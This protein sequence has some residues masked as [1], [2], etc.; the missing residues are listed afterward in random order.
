MKKTADQ[1]I[2]ETL[3]SPPKP[4][5]SSTDKW[6]ILCSA[7]EMLWQLSLLLLAILLMLIVIIAFFASLMKVALFFWNWVF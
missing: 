3:N 6:F 5:L 1:Q 2:E 4:K 7:G